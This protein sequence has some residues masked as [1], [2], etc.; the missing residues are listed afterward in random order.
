VKGNNIGVERIDV[1]SITLRPLANKRPSL[2]RFKGILKI[3]SNNKRPLYDESAR[4]SDYMG[5]PPCKHCGSSIHATD[6]KHNGYDEDGNL[7]ENYKCPSCGKWF[8][9]EYDGPDDF[10]NARYAEE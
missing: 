3:K 6:M 5:C 1:G 4:G 10:C 8:T 9:V 7:Y 2:S